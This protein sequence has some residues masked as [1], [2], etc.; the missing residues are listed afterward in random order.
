MHKTVCAIIIL[1]AGA[2]AAIAQVPGTHPRE[3]AP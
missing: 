1:V 2:G 3:A